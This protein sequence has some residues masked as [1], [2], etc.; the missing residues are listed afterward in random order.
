MAPTSEVPWYGRETAVG[1]VAVV[2]GYQHLREFAES[3]LGEG[4]LMVNEGQG[5]KECPDG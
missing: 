5:W 2:S 1:L 4:R 3:Q